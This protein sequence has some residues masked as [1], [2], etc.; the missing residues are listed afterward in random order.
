MVLA[1]QNLPADE[2]DVRVPVSIPGLGRSPG[3]GHGNSLYYSCLEN[4]MDR[5][6]W[7]AT[8]H[9]VAKSWTRLK[10]LSTQANQCVC[11]KSKN[12][13]LCNPEK[14]MGP[15]CSTLAWKIPWM[16]EP[17]GLQSMWSL[18]VGHD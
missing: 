11:P 15:H 3:G 10:R 2:G 16:E 17:G 5:A 8:V 13:L 9:G 14:A 6:A 12:I 18:R 1:V 4:P 7:R